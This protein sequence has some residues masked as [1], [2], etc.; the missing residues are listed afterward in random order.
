VENQTRAALA[1]GNVGTADAVVLA[2]DREILRRLAGQ[3]ATLARR[4]AEAEK[5]RLWAAHND[6][7]PTR[8]LIFCDPENGWTEIIPEGRLECIG[9][10]ARRWEKRLR[11]EIFGGERMGDDRVIEPFFDVSHVYHESD[12]GMHE[13]KIGGDHGGSYNWESPLR[14]WSQMDQLHFPRI[15]VA[16]EATHQ[17]LE[18]ARLVLGDL[19]EVRLRTRWWWTLGMTWTLANLRGMEQLMLDML[20]SPDELKHL[21]AFLRDGHLAKLDYLE[22]HGLLAPNHDSSYVGSGGF[23]NTRQL[24][25]PGYDETR[26][27]TT[28]MWGF[29]E[30]QETVG[31][32]PEMFAEFVYPYQLPIL[33]RFGLNCYGCCEPLNKRWHVIKDT[34][35]LRR[36]SVSPW[37]DLPVMAEQLQD[38]FIYSRKP[39]PTSLA[40]ERIDEDSVRHGLRETLAITRGCRL[41]IIMKDNH[42]LGGNP[43]NAVNWCR[44][45]RE[46]IDRAY[47]A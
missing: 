25:K 5:R 3:V 45:A 38:R 29:C 10:L 40:V 4:P 33:K 42:T 1:G 36:V 19:L 35:N 39:S 6:L 34:P 15:E 46:E 28:D 11:K 7:Q 14:D 47:K 43:D 21:M 8:P 41:E 31:V 12:W 27:R 24:P 22:Q 2:G 18:L 17:M 26:V 32:S 23:G 20:D 16:F 9:D 44:I 30:S 13:K 37:A